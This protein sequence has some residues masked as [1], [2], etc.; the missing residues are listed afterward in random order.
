MASPLPPTLVSDEAES[1]PSIVA[2]SLNHEELLPSDRASEQ[3]SGEQEPQ[4]TGDENAFRPVA[5]QYANELHGRRHQV[6]DGKAAHAQP[7]Q[8]GAR[9][10]FHMRSRN[11]QNLALITPFITPNFSRNHPC[12]KDVQYRAGMPSQGVPLAALPKFDES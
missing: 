11:R 10:V 12:S 7:L 1:H 4:S 9:D 5:V 3:D 2:H 6:Y 8:A